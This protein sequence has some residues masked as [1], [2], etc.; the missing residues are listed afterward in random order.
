MSD[1]DCTS[2]WDDMSCDL[3][4]GHI[5][6]HQKNWVAR[7]DED[8]TGVYFDRRNQAV[9]DEQ[10]E[11]ATVARANHLRARHGLPPLSMPDVLSHVNADDWKAETR[12]ALEAARGV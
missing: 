1:D 12:A 9:T 11:A 6:D 3:I 5:G 7:W 2:T 10:V 4:R 8:C